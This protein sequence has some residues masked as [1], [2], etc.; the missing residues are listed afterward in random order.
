MTQ[1]A[2]KETEVQTYTPPPQSNIVAVG[3]SQVLAQAMEK[4]ASIEQLTQLLDLQDRFE[5]REAEKAFNLA[6]ADFKANPPKILKD[7]HVKFE[8]QKG[9]TEYNHSSLANVVYTI[10]QGL[11]EHGL[12]AIWETQQ[13]DGGLITVTC[14]LSHKLGHQTRTALMAGRDDSGGKNNIQALGSTVSYLQRYTLLAATGLATH[15][16]DDDGKSSELPAIKEPVT[17]DQAIEIGDL[18]KES[19]IDKDKFLGFFSGKVGYQLTSVEQLP[20]DAY[21][22]AK[23]LIAKQSKG[24]KNATA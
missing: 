16:Q 9:T 15:D 22:A 24:A 11:S 1:T 7:K 19:G 21:E 13:G 12:S 10:S 2:N 18:I 20:A 5:R 4:G 14:I 17:T 3:P 8:T 6:L 23:N